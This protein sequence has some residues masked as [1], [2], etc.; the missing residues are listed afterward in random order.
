MQEAKEESS[1]RRLGEAGVGVG[2]GIGIGIGVGIGMAM[3]MAMEGD[4]EFQIDA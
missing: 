3:A 4:E 2:V 1:S